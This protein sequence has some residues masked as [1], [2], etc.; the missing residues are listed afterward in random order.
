ML[1]DNSAAHSQ[2]DSLNS[3]RM[4]RLSNDNKFYEYRSDTKSAHEWQSGNKTSY[5]KTTDL[6]R[7]E[8]IDWMKGKQAS[9]HKE[10]MEALLGALEDNTFYKD[11]IPQHYL[12]MI[13]SVGDEVVPFSNYEKCI[14]YW[15]K[16]EEAKKYVR[17]LRYKGL[18]QT[19]VSFGKCFFVQEQGWRMRHIFYDALKYLSFDSTTWGGLTE[20]QQLA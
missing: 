1:L 13:H 10:K 18:S 17:G 7:P 4:Y 5:A 6:L 12:F 8:V 19:H 2:A 14:E 15:G 3:L 20:F 9:E 16:S 11:W